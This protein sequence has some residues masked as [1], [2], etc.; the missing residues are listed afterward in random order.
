MFLMNCCL[1][2]QNAF[3]RSSIFQ[4]VVPLCDNF[5]EL[6]VDVLANPDS[7]MGKFVQHIFQHALQVLLS[8]RQIMFCTHIYMFVG[9][10]VL[11]INWSTE[12]QNIVRYSTLVKLV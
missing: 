8:Y 6:I 9:C 10:V 1:K 7:I 3:T 2:F 11:V 12:D 5:W 4:N